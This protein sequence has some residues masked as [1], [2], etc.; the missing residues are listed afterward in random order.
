MVFIAVPDNEKK[1]KIADLSIISHQHFNYF[2][3]N[4]LK[5]LM[6]KADFK[7]I[8]LINSK[9]RSV[10]FAWG[11]K[12]EGSKNRMPLRNDFSDW[13]IFKKFTI[14][15][16]KNV[17]TIQRLIEGYE[18]KGKK[19][20]LYAPCANLLGLLK[21]KKTPRIFQGDKFKHGKFMAGYPKAIEP[22]GKLLKEPVDILFIAPIDYDK[23]IRDYLIK[24]GLNKKKT[25]I[26]SLKGI[27][28]KNSG[29]KYKVSSK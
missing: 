8:R 4:S 26:V 25:E 24:M 1:L 22:P 14:N 13:S 27:Y 17:D 9:K 7:N 6:E 23:E 20:G 18:K 11:T 10:I 19:I 2:T 16:L 3:K 12:K 29:I 15:L 5:K 21:F 28:E